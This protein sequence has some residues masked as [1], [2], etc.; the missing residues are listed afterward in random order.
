MIER[1]EVHV[2]TQNEHG[3]YGTRPIELRL[4]LPAPPAQI[5]TWMRPDELRPR[6]SAGELAWQDDAL[7]AQ[8]DPEA[9][10]PEKGGSVAP[11]KRICGRCTVRAACLMYAF[12]T[13]ED[14]GIWGGLSYNERKQ[15]RKRLNKTGGVTLEAIER[16]IT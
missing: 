16:A 15:L 6:D 8:T 9:F 3:V 7:C 2:L 14:M 4:E 12:E 5:P 10:L 11:A 1:G 13:N